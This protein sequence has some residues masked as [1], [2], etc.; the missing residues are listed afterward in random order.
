MKK[1]VIKAIVITIVVLLCIYFGI[2]GYMASA[3]TNLERVLVTESPSSYGLSYEEV[4]F[5]SRVDNLTLRGWY[6]GGSEGHPVI[7]MVHGAEGNRASPSMGMLELA[8][9]LVAEGYSVLMFDLRGHGESGGAHM[10]GGYYE[11]RDLLGAVDYL[12][13]R[14]AV[15][16]GVLGFSLGAAVA[17][18][19]AA[20]EPGISA[21]V[22]D[23]SFADLTD[24]I[25]REAEIRSGLPGWFTPGYLLMTRAMYG[26][27]LEAVK[28]IDAV[29]EIAP[30]PIFFIHGEADDFIPVAH[31]NRL[32]E[33]SNNQSNLLWTVP[34]AKHLEPYK[35]VPIEYIERVTTFFD[36]EL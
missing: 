9:S 34:G 10:S 8:S 12:E 20:E 28:P 13:G 7:I 29:A 14:G 21:I 11:K 16:I 15:D 24:I 35:I 3:L 17:I 23:S 31:V 6:I 19:A 33:A 32:Y 36:K 26:V 27:D 18:L 1:K 5:P 30:R 4:S 22:A 2:S 25:N